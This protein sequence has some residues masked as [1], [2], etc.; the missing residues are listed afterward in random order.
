MVEKEFAKNTTV[1]VGNNAFVWNGEY[2][3]E[4]K[5]ENK[6]YKKISDIT[7]GDKYKFKWWSTKQ[8][9]TGFN[10]IDGDEYFLMNSTQVYAIWEKSAE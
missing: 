7:F 2:N 1:G 10:Y 9:G 6:I 8:D 3:G 4:Q 5:E